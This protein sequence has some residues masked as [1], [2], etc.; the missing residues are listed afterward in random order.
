MDPRLVLY[1]SKMWGISR[2]SF[3]TLFYNLLSSSYGHLVWN[4][5]GNA[6]NCG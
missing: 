4:S 5:L 6:E 1:V 3:I 2:P